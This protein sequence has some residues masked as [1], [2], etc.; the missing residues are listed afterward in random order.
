MD[1]RAAASRE[2]IK[3]AFL[4]LLACKPLSELK[5]SELARQAGVSRS[6]LYAHYET[7]RAVFD[8]LVDDFV[9]RT[10]GLSVQLRCQDCHAPHSKAPFC[11][12]L[13]AAGPYQ[14]LVLDSSFLAQFLHVILDDAHAEHALA[15]YLDTGI[16]EG[17]ARS[18]L[19]FQISGCYMAAV[20]ADCNAL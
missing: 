2:L 8:E 14:P 19:V 9:A 4:S 15:P 16:S 1:K 5:M 18:M 6:T 3:K 17:Q 20:N 13:R 12:Q 10:S 11:E 7:P